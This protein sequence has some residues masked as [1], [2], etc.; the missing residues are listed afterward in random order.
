MGVGFGVR[1]NPGIHDAVEEWGA[2]R[3]DHHGWVA[4][5]Q[6]RRVRHVAQHL[7]R[8]HADLSMP[9]SLRITRLHP[10]ALPYPRMCPARATASFV[11]FLDLHMPSLYSY[12]TLF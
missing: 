6:L 9:L 3:K 8:Q 1:C 5:R 2:Q 10:P 4:G 11:A 7:Q 12:V